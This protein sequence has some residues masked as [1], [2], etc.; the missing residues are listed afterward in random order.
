MVFCSV[1]KFVN[2]LLVEKEV[3]LN[4]I[5]MMFVWLV[6][7]FNFLVLNLFIV[8][9]RFVV[10]V[11]FLGEG[12]RF[13]G[14]N[15]LFNWVILGIILGVVMSMLKFIMFFW[16]FLINFLELVMLVLVLVVFLIFFF[17]VSMVICIVCFVFLGKE[18]VVWICWLLYLGLM[19]RW[20][21]VL[22]VLLNLVVV[23]FLSNFMVFNG[24]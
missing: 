15:C 16:I 20:M 12:M 19:F 1:F 18:I 7:N 10:I 8:V 13:W 2:K 23:V 5:W 11:F 17:W 4:I 24:L 3:F 6:W 21:W 9:V 14:F 22:V